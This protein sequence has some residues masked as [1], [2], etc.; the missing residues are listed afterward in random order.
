MRRVTS[1]G[2]AAAVLAAVPAWAQTGP[3][4]TALR[5]LAPVSALARTPE[6][7]AA[8][9]ANLAVTGDIQ[10][11]AAGQP[12]LLPLAEQRQ[13][14]LRDCFITDG[15]AAELADGLG[16]RLGAIYQGKARY[17]DHKT[18]TSVA[19]S[20]ADLIGYTNNI[21]KSDSNAGKFFFATRPPTQGAG[22][23]GRAAILA[24]QGGTRTCSAAPTTARP[25]ARG[26]DAYGN[27][28]PFQTLPQLHGLSRDR[29]FRPAVAQPRLAARPEPGPHRQPVLPERPHHLRL[30]RVARPRDPGAGT[31]PADDRPRRRVRQQPHRRRRH[32]AMDVLGGR[33]VALHAV[34][35]LLAND[36]AYVGQVR[37]NPAVLDAMSTSASDPVAITDYRAAVAA[38]RRRP[39]GRPA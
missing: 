6:G 15:N 20:V 17:A 4:L 3:N 8:L 14:A 36:P 23:G 7:R 32:Y 26:A 34:A 33:T 19:P 13:L 31:L 24:A 28:R 21:T 11:G 39:A 25:A 30:H 10:S 22:L 27:S 16:A 35:H 9:A 18:F 2:I 5:G 37:R 12:L 38:A 29:L 1:I